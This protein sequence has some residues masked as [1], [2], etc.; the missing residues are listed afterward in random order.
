MDNS[1]ESMGRGWGDL[2][3]VQNPKK[4]FCFTQ[5]AEAA[6]T[7]QLSSGLSSIFIIANGGIKYC[8]SLSL[9]G[10]VYANILQ[11]N[12]TA[13]LLSRT[14]LGVYKCSQTCINVG[15]FISARAVAGGVADIKQGYT[16]SNNNKLPAD[17]HP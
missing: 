2:S 1:T 9:Q 4:Q 16:D 17:F 7:H 13:F 15:C 11:Y 3:F 12:F 6:V 5:S 14:Q 8:A 10:H